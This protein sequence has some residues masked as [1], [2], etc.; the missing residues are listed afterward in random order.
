MPH[1]PAA[2]GW[3]RAY[4]SLTCTLLLG[5]IVVYQ[6]FATGIALFYDTVSLC[7]SAAR[8]LGKADAVALEEMPSIL[9]VFLALARR[10][11]RKSLSD[12]LQRS[13]RLLHAKLLRASLN[14]KVL[15]VGILIKCRFLN[16]RYCGCH[17]LQY[18]VNYL[19]LNTNGQLFIRLFLPPWQHL[20]THILRWSLARL[21]CI[22]NKALI[23]A[24]SI[25][26]VPLRGVRFG[27]VPP[28]ETLRRFAAAALQRHLVVER[29]ADADVAVS[30][31]LPH[32]L[33]STLSRTFQSVNGSGESFAA[34]SS[35]VGGEFDA[36]DGGAL[37]DGWTLNAQG[38]EVLHKSGGGRSMVV[39]V[40][41]D[42]DARL[43]HSNGSARTFIG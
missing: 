36:T 32:S 33:H 9:Q 13:L 8:M 22:R 3:T 5:D 43:P 38:Q 29:D 20:S 24:Q 15:G 26:A 42:R 21:L 19:K 25:A 31:N 14:F 16:S 39:V 27:V 1:Y 17:L 12:W 4:F 23:R 30:M 34:L 37:P 41:R 18:R 28:Q 6:F 2:G 7:S 10:K 35:T 11:R 40:E